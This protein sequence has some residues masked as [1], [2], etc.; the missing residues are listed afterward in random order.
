MPAVEPDAGVPV[1]EVE[2][3]RPGKHGHI[4]ALPAVRGEAEPGALPVLRGIAAAV[5]HLIPLIEQIAAVIVHQQ[6]AV[7]L[8]QDGHLRAQG[9]GAGD[10]RPLGRAEQQPQV[11]PGVS[12]LSRPSVFRRLFLFLFLFQLQP[13]YLFS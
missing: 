4:A 5:Q 1:G 10:V 2:G 3:I 13:F 6:E 8:R 11:I 9:I 7:V 12:R